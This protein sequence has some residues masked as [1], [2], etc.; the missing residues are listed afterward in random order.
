MNVL[1]IGVDNPVSVAASGGGDDKTQVS[2]SGGGGSVTKVGNG[3]YN[4]RV[5]SVTDDCRINVSVDGKLAGAS[6]FRVRSI[7]TPAAFVGGMESGRGTTAASLANQ[8]GI[9]A[10][11]KDFPF[12]LRYTVSEYTVIG[13][14]EDGDIIKANGNGPTFTQQARNIIKVAK[15]GDQIS[16]NNI[17]CIGPDGARRKLPGL[18]Y[19]IN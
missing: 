11:I 9:F 5:S 1:Y 16:I 4:I 14:N 6:Q 17:Y 10:G 3:K 12:E 15:P 13:L 8:E 18:F 7:P 19:N 2:I